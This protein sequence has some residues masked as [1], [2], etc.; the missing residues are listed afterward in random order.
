[1]ISLADPVGEL[2]LVKPAFGE[3]SLE[4]VDDRLSVRGR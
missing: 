2:F 3:R 4:R 1:V